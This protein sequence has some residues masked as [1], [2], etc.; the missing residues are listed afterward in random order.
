[1]KPTKDEVIANLQSI[2]NDQKKRLSL[3]EKVVEAAFDMADHFDVMRLEGCAGDCL[4]SLR[5]ALAAYRSAK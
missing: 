2:V 3:A 4:T 1:M 5:E